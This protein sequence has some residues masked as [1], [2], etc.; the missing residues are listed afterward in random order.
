MRTC[1][2]ALSLDCPDATKYVHYRKQK[3]HTTRATPST[4]IADFS[5]QSMPSPAAATNTH[6]R[7]LCSTF[8]HCNCASFVRNARRLLSKQSSILC[9]SHQ[10][11]TELGQMHHRL[12]SNETKRFTRTPAHR[13]RSYI[14][15]QIKIHKT[16]A[17]CTYPHEIADNIFCSSKRMAENYSPLIE[18]K[19]KLCACKYDVRQLIL[20]PHTVACRTEQNN[21]QPITNTGEAGHDN[22]TA[23]KKHRVTH[24][25]KVEWKSQSDQ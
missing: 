23:H 3:S 24:E 8:F 13:T 6:S 18:N 16:T 11:H 25:Q 12:K 1:S 20:L 9:E 7:D 2:V 10:M 15:I 4:T 17:R 5:D 21:K 22:H 14:V 19:W